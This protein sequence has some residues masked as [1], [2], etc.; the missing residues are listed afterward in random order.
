MKQICYL[1]IFLLSFVLEAKPA[2]LNYPQTQKKLQEI[3]SMHACFQSLSPQIIRRALTLYLE[4]LDPTKTY[5]LKEEIDSWVYPSKELLE[6]TLLGI[7]QGNFTVFEEID[8]AFFLAAERRDALEDKLQDTTLPKEQDRLDLKELDWVENQT[9]LE[10]RILSIRSIQES[11]ISKMG[12]EEKQKLLKRIDQRRKQR[13]EQRKNDPKEETISTYAL[14]A[15]TSSLDS[16]T[17]F[18][19][20]SEAKQFIIQVQQKLVGIG[21][22]LRDDLEGPCVMRLLEGG[23]A[24]LSNKLKLND[25][26]IAVNQE[27]LIGLELSEAV[28]KIR[29]EKGTKVHLTLLREEE[30]KAQK[31][32]VELIRN[33]VVL[34]ESRYQTHLEPFADGQILYFRL[35]SFYQD[36]KNSSASDLKKAIQ[37]AKE[38]GPLKGVVLDLRDNAG[39]LLNQAVAVSGLFMQSGIV[40]SIK[41]YAKK[42]HHLREIDPSI[43][44][45]GPLCILINRGSASASEIVAGTLQDY[46][47]GLVI[48]DNHSFGKGTFQTLTLDNSPHPKVDPKGEFKVTRGTY[49]TVSGRS[50]QLEGVFSDI[51]VPGLLSQADIGEAFEKYPLK[52]DTIEP[53]FIDP[54]T[55]LS[56]FHKIQLKAN[57]QKTQQPKKTTY[58]PYLTT[59]KENSRARISANKAYQACLSALKEKHFDSPLIDT[60]HQSDLQLIEAL[61]ILKDLLYL[62]EIPSSKAS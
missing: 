61:N 49:Y 57:Y 5:F 12:A 7:Q 41:D 40:V 33:E 10:K 31:Q 17:N 34:E 62:S 60:F 51:E 1:I 48:G 11:A 9:H 27:P 29:G 22:Q 20:P 36:E 42:V 8:Q 43:S 14:K 56:P 6:K 59:L 4:E 19:T 13:Q 28:E 30:G 35:F 45:K 50:P 32:E 25:K 55:D 26:I 58:L 37:E 38:K 52:N 18:L 53:C 16:H 54:L 3:L 47:R 21:A 23:P 46:G 15:I 39:G 24:L 44:W 2:A